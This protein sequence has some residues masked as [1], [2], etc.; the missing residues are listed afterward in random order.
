M[1]KV[2]W[3]KSAVLG[4]E[5]SHNPFPHAVSLIVNCLASL[6]PPFPAVSCPAGGRHPHLLPEIVTVFPTCAKCLSKLDW[7]V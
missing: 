1:L 5:F 7:G 3:V 4:G 6:L 2:N